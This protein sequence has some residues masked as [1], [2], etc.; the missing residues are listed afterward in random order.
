MFAAI[1]TFP[2]GWSCVEFGILFF[3]ILNIGSPNQMN[4]L[5][6]ILFFCIFSLV[7]F[8]QVGHSNW[9]KKEHSL[10]D[11]YYKTHDLPVLGKIEQD[12]ES[13]IT[14]VTSFF[15]DSFRHRFDFYLFP[16]RQELT[17]QWRKD[18]GMPEFNAQC[19]MVA[20]GVAKRLDILSPLAWQDDACEHNP[21]DS[22]EI[23]Q[24]IIHELVHVFHAQHNPRPGFAEME[25][26]DWLVEG[27]ATY[28]SGQLSQTRLNNIVMRVRDGEIPA[29][30][31]V[32]WQASDKYGMAGSFVKF[33]DLHFG[34]QKLI[35]LLP[36]NELS[37]ILQYLGTSEQV[38][39]ELWRKDLIAK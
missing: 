3:R 20:S 30:L 7:S 29:S 34:R 9:L 24:I 13:G 19:W 35:G 37:A 8:G 10:F 26:L 21:N 28:A 27:L 12:A 16:E 4:R 14:S 18:W 22:I 23:K 6:T 1:R 25:S 31:S 32:L 2:F 11:L 5:I 36:L 17:E 39:I 15:N 38:L 33:I